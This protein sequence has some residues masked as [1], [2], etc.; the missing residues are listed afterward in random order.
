MKGSYYGL[1]CGA[2]GLKTQ[3]NIEEIKKKG[4]VNKK[5]K[6]VH[7][8]ITKNSYKIFQTTCAEV[9]TKATVFLPNCNT[10]LPYWL[11]GMLYI[12]MHN[13]FEGIT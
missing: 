5:K 4:N 1:S 9:Y 3:T 13:A 2:K 8:V 7:L 11:R 12:I 6:L 10:V